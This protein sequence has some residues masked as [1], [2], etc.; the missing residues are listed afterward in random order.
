MSANAK[1]GR[2]LN[3]ALVGG[4][5]LMV[6]CCAVGPAVI[7]AAAGSAMM[8][9]A[10]HRLRRRA[11]EFIRL[12]LTARPPPPTAAHR[13]ARPLHAVLVIAATT[14]FV[15]GVSI[16]RGNEPAQH[17]AGEAA[18]PSGEAGG[19][20]EAQHSAGES[21]AGATNATEPHAEL[22]PLG[23]DVEAWPFVIAAALASLA[24]AAAAWLRPR[25]TPL[26]ALVAVAM[27]A[28]AALD[29]R[30]VI[31]QADIN[32]RGLAV[33]AGAVAA[34]HLAAAAVAA[35]MAARSRSSV[36]PS[37][38]PAGTMPA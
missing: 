8:D 29:L 12:I 18:A 34:L 33:L 25:L 19:E 6:L 21:A 23:I 37:A 4:S 26:L 38:R 16:E 36:A 1:P 32:E 11:G 5:V 3:Y 31:H 14:A 28:F 9:A 2:E 7:G 13:P 35:A 20:G 17:A 24:L 22:R 15:V 27:L 10:R 30:E